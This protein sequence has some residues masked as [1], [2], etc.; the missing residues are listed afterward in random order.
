MIDL[1]DDAFGSAVREALALAASEAPR[2]EPLHTGPI[3]SALVRVDAGAT[4]ERL[5]LPTGAWD[6]VTAGMQARDPGVPAGSAYWRGHPLTAAAGLALARLRLLPDA[7]DMLPVPPGALALMALAEPA[8]GAARALLT[9]GAVSHAEL[10]VLVQ[11]DLLGT[12]LGG[13]DAFLAD[14][15]QLDDLVTGKDHVGDGDVERLVLLF[16]TVDELRD[17]RVLVERHPHLL[18]P[19]VDTVID[20]ALSLARDSGDVEL[21]DAVNAR[22]RLLHRIRDVGITDAFLEAAA[23]TGDDGPVEVSAATQRITA[24]LLEYVNAA[25]MDESRRVLQEY[26]E[27]LLTEQAELA[28]SVFLDGAETAGHESTGTLRVHLTFLRRC[29][30]VGI[31]AAFAELDP[32]SRPADPAELM[33]LVM[34]FAGTPD[35]DE[36]RGLVDGNRVLLGAAAAALMDE[37]LRSARDGGI[38]DAVRQIGLRR[39][40]LQRCAEI[41]VDAAFAEM[42][43]STDA[44]AHP[45]SRVSAAD[46]ARGLAIMRF[47]MTTDWTQARE[48]L[49]ANPVLLTERAQ[50][51]FER[52]IEDATTPREIALLRMHQQLLRRCIDIGTDAAFAEVEES[53]DTPTPTADGPPLED[54]VR[55]FLLTPDLAE[56]RALVARWPQLRSAQALD[57]LTALVDH[58]RR[59]GSSDL[60]DGVK[61]R[62]TVLREADAPDPDPLP[63]VVS[64]LVERMPPSLV[65]DL[66]RDEP[67][68]LRIGDAEFDRRVVVARSAGNVALVAALDQIRVLRSGNRER[69]RIFGRLGAAD[70]ALVPPLLELA[71]AG[72]P[73]EASL[74]IA[75]H[76]ALV[77]EASGRVLAVLIEAAGS[78]GDGSAARTFIEVR[79]LLE[80]ARHADTAPD[81][82]PPPIAG[83]LA[84]VLGTHDEMAGRGDS[85]EAQVEWLRKVAG[86]FEM[87]YRMTG[88]ADSLAAAVDCWS[89]AVGAASSDLAGP[90]ATQRAS[91]LTNLGNAAADLATHD[92]VRI[93][94][95]IDAY[96]KAVEIGRN[97]SAHL[98]GLLGN[99]ADGLRVRFDRDRRATD[100]DGMIDALR[101][102]RA[103]ASATHPLLDTI[104]D[105]L[106]T[107]L[108]MRFDR[109]GKRVDLDD[110]H[111]LHAQAG[112][113]DGDWQRSCSHGGTMTRLAA[114]DRRPELLD[115]AEQ[116]FTAAAREAPG[117]ESMATA[118]ACIGDV[119]STRFRLTGDRSAL[120][121]AVAVLTDA[122]AAAPRGTR[123]ATI[124]S[125][126]ADEL[127]NRYDTVGQPADIDAALEQ[128]EQA[129]LELA[130]D[131]PHWADAAASIGQRHLQRSMFTE[132]RADL[133]SAV[134]WAERAV[135]ARPED[136]AAA[137]R[138]RGGLGVALRA[139]YETIGDPVD[140]DASLS[141][142]AAAVIAAS[143]SNE[144]SVEHLSAWGQ[145]LL[146]RFRARGETADIDLAVTVL[147]RATL[148]PAAKPAAIGHAQDVLASALRVRGANSPYGTDLD[149]AVALLEERL[150]ATQSDSPHRP[151]RLAALA[152][153]LDD[154]HQRDHDPAALDR[155]IGMGREALDAAGGQWRPR[156]SVSSALADML[157]TRGGAADIAEAVRLGTAAVTGTG[158][159]HPEKAGYHG[160]LAN[161]LRLRGNAGDDDAATRHYRRCC[162]LAASTDPRSVLA[163]A[164]QWG[165]WAAQ[166]AAWSEMAEAYTFGAD[167]LR[168]L[169][170]R[171]VSRRDKLGWLLGTR[172]I[173][174]NLAYART[175]LGD[176]EAAV[177]A[178]ER[179]RALLLA[180]KLGRLTERSPTTEPT[181]ADVAAAARPTAICYLLAAAPGG[182]GLIVS[183]EG[184]ANAV[185]LPE[186]DSGELRRRTLQFAAGL[187]ELHRG[188][189]M[190][191]WDAVIDDLGRWLWTAAAG[192]LI[193]ALPPGTEHIVIIPGGL[194]G[195]LP[196]HAACVA[197]PATRTGRR[198]LIDEVCVSYSPAAAATAAAQ[199]ASATPADSIL[200]VEEPEPTTEPAIAKARDEAEHVTRVMVGSLPLRSAD[201][202]VLHLRGRAATRDAVLQ[203]VHDHAVLH[204]CCHGRADPIEPLRGALVMARD[205][206]LTVADLARRRSTP[207]RLAVL[208]ACDSAVQGAEIP[209]EAIGFPSSLIQAGFAGVVG[210]QWVVPD[211]VAWR[212]TTAFYTL[213]RQE[214]LSPAEALRRAQ[215]Q[216]RDRS[217]GPRAGS[218]AAMTFTGA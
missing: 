206:H 129:I 119:H 113:E 197:D 6:F 214:G 57:R 72:S 37:L 7:F 100:L 91:L 125:M 51:S 53:D 184:D 212:I 50:L 156:N 1:D 90:A 211:R 10:L 157:V 120:D 41:G 79:E 135:R 116:A 141:E 180:E 35:L 102:A 146:A 31:D 4:W 215:Q 193:D 45:A 52:L 22:A 76:P 29:R 208:S 56:A 42:R 192:P 69:G 177:V 130:P 162:A 48:I 169:V 151:G 148:V 179:G 97:D 132:G 20:T 32:I 55:M 75:R 176:T 152:N 174:A 80:R 83:L 61:A 126:L 143:E 78:A 171:Q 96:S 40:L 164:H 115:D 19:A 181:F 138:H 105:N 11:S 153:A 201:E 12:R 198:Y 139:R 191:A 95:V 71:A 47:V 200:V 121:A 165:R 216:E 122:V 186:L 14:T 3:L 94:E 204:L 73:D 124:R 134:G 38:E 84:G 159:A 175:M 128:D 58:I 106:A 27:V 111:T 64:R 170:G 62:L 182:L 188:G 168:A 8:A 209:D 44:D 15:R 160:V 142:H 98:A 92:P 150:T 185:M 65:V 127:S 196:I 81:E 24:L 131:S 114:L 49:D 155:A 183:T 77:S 59:T 21:I 154:R 136:D 88:E 137:A 203:A 123:R 140:L 217:S 54:L 213:W 133:D 66:L 86:M 99:L 43:S 60:I 74:V 89:R 16:L 2:D 173:T 112:P 210:T 166:R 87:R 118:L 25:D 101:A 149:G 108:V 202:A 158:D 33:P 13:L 172:T 9:S 30:A 178:A 145:A 23:W 117:A 104:V 39:V 207:A 218:W 17:A 85:A 26:R 190:S 46:Q 18:D 187:R 144:H 205:Q 5:W 68:I 34:G 110:A 163:V 36:A 63:S 67:A 195:V 147:R 28:L 189:P 103:A 82:G 109:G 70:H 107:A 199:A 167:T 161:A 93:D 194:L